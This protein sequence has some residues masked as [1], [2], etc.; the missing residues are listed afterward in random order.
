MNQPA[1]EIMLALGLQDRMVGTAY[2]DDEVL[3]EYAAYARVP[4]LAKEYP[5]KEKLLEAEPDFVYT[6]F[7]SAFSD[8]GAGDRAAWE[9]LGAGTTPRPAAPRKPVQPN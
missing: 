9:K 1:T 3:P 6:S 7:N 8:E 4:V 2:L 5:S